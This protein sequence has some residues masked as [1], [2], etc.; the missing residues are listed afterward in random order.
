M[1]GKFPFGEEVHKVVQQERAPKPVF[2][3]EVYAN[4]VHAR[5]VDVN[6][7]TVVELIVLPICIH[8]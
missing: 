4:A 1:I 5:W 2:I 7:R 6:E 8:K 3:L